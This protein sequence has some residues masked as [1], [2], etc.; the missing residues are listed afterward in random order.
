M[1]LYSRHHKMSKIFIAPHRTSNGLSCILTLKCAFSQN[2]EWLRRE[3]LTCL[4]VIRQ[5]NQKIRYQLI[6][7]IPGRVYF[8][9]RKSS[10]LSLPDRKNRFLGLKRRRKPWFSMYVFSGRTLGRTSGRVQRTKTFGRS[11][12]KQL[13]RHAVPVE[14]V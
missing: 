13:T 6:N 4:Q 9:V 3:Y 8:K 14:Q 10:K 12:Q 1:E 5:G 7:L 11:A 2:A